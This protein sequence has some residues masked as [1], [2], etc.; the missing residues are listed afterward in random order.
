[1]AWMEHEYSIKATKWKMSVVMTVVPVRAVKAY[2]V[3]EVQLHSQP[4]H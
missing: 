4:R 2:R 1:L 3:V